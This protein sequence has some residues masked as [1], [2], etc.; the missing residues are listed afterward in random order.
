MEGI[1]IEYWIKPIYDINNNEIYSLLNNRKYQNNFKGTKSAIQESN[2]KKL[3]SL[4]VQCIGTDTYDVFIIKIPDKLWCDGI[5]SKF[6]NLE[7]VIS[8]TFT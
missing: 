2:R 7:D 4:A 1:D 6:I 5:L 8:L 3:C